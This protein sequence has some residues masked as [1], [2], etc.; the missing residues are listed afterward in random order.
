MS[1]FLDAELRGQLQEAFAPLDRDVE[2]LV[3]TS[4]RVVL[5][6][7]EPAGEEA[8]TQQLLRDVAETSPRLSVVER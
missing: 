1:Q 7:A 5:P 2:M 8:A 3:Y 4:S 6:G